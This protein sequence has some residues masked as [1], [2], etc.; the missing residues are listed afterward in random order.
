MLDIEIFRKKLGIIIE[1]EKKRFKDPS[2]AERV[3]EYDIKWRTA[4]QHIEELRKQRNEISVKISEFKKKK[5]MKKL[6]KQ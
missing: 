4:L 5:M 2:I 6:K 1:S 3:L